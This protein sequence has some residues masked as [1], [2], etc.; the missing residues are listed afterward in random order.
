MQ[1]ARVQSG[2]DRSVPRRP[3]PARGPQAGLGAI[4][5]VAG[6]GNWS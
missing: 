1:V 2:H 6:S 3:G 5:D 4:D